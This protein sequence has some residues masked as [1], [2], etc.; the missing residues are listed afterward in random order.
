[1]ER[2]YQIARFFGLFFLYT[3]IALDLL[4]NSNDSEVFTN[5]FSGGRMQHMEFDIS[6]VEMKTLTSALEKYLSELRL[7]ITDA[8][9][10]EFREKLREEKRIIYSFL[11][12]LEEVK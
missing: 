2:Y 7:E 1:M 6:E 9:N 8:D 3:K 11:E 5:L 10:D 4:E 12:K